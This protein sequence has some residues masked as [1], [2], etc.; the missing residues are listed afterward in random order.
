VRTCRSQ[1]FRPGDGQFK[2]IGDAILGSFIDTSGRP[3]QPG[4]GWQV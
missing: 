2:K 3:I 4:Q 1:G